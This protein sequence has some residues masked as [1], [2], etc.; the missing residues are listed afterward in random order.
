[1]KQIHIKLS[2]L[3]HRELK[4]QA[5][6]NGQ[7]IQDYVIEAIKNQLMIDKTTSSA[8]FSKEVDNDNSSK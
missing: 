1:M 5:V 3:L 6:F 8:N 2:E 7:T 4:M